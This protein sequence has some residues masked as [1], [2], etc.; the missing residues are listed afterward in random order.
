M[1][2]LEKF[3]ASDFSKYYQLVSDIRVM[4]QITE[5]AIPGT[6]AKEKF[7]KLL[8]RNQQ[9]DKFGSF[10]IY[11]EQTNTYIGLAHITP[12][13]QQAGKAEIGYMLLPDYWRQGYGRAAAEKLVEMAVAAQLK[14][15]TAII[16]P[17]NT[18]SKKILI[19]NG[20]HSTFKG[21]MD[22]LA[23]EILTKQLIS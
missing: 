8:R 1:I 2:R 21:V 23:T 14:E 20:F 6:E 22:G 11:S 4:A 5:R 16:D 9:V 13:E 12:D 15:I 18:A 3:T 19:Q 17:E 7:E 10:K